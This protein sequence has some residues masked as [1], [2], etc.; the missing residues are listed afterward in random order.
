M[1]TPSIK[2]SKINLLDEKSVGDEYLYSLVTN[3]YPWVA[4]K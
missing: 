4:H 3:E 1:D 2:M